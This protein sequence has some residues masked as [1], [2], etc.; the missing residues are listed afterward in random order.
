MTPYTAYLT[1]VRMNQAMK[2]PPNTNS[3]VEETS[4]TTALSAPPPTSSALSGRA[5]APRP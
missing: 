1:G 2:M 4:R 5:P 3:S